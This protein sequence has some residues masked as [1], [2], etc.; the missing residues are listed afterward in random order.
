M[1]GEVTPKCVGSISSCFEAWTSRLLLESSQ[2]SG[3]G[4]KASLFL[5]MFP[6]INR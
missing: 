2:I 4:N 6:E 1:E 5:V 3:M